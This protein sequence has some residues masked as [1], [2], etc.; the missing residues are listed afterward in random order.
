[1]Q[2][3]AGIFSVSERDEIAIGRQAAAQVEQKAPILK[4][5]RIQ[6]Y[7]SSLGHEL[8]RQSSR[9]HLPWRFRV[10]E[11]K[12][13]NA[14]ALPGG[15]IYV[16]SR[17]LEL[18]SS[19]AELAGVIAHEI[20]HIEGF[21]HKTQL[22]RAM[23]YRLGLGVLGAV[24]GQGSG[25]DYAMIAGKL[26]AQGQLTKYSR[27]A[28]ADADRRGVNILYK[29]G[30]DPMAMSRFLEN[31]VR[32]DRRQPGILSGFFR[33]HPAARDRVASTRAQARS[34]PATGHRP[35]S[36]DF[37]EMVRRLQGG[38]AASHMADRERQSEGA[39]IL[40][41]QPQYPD[42]QGALIHPSRP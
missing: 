33:D 22:E 28:E 27:E 36:P 29:A 39:L 15:F 18:A 37:L 10:I 25:A 34:L 12:N 8:A 4:D 2:V 16:H 1:M 5:S 13:I 26:L 11:D 7:I 19:E 14:F 38:M 24:A 40:P 35:D 32:L 6:A 17:I 30:F 9:P 20:G 41:R 42:Q 31:L 23:R 21:H 3:H